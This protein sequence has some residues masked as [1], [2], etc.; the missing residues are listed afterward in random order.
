MAFFRKEMFWD[1]QFEKLDIEKNR[2]LIIQRVV[3]FGTWEEFLK[4]VNQYGK[5]VV[6]EESLLNRELSDQGAYFLSHYFEK[7]IKDFV[8]YKKRQLS[9]IHFHF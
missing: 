2:N 6:I 9:P 3:D 5:K 1:I 8:C 7:N 4:M